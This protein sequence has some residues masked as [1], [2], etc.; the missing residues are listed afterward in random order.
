MTHEI[1]KCKWSVAQLAKK[2][3]ALLV[4]RTLIPKYRCRGRHRENCVVISSISKLNGNG[5]HASL[6][7]LDMR[8]LCYL[9]QK[10]GNIAMRTPVLIRAS[11]VLCK[12]PPRRHHDVDARP[13]ATASSS[14]G[15][16]ISMERAQGWPFGCQCC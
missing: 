3:T 1:T 11:K 12:A 2:C 4:A 13:G 10:W 7:L 9:G 15:Y 14:I 6:A 8:S 16:A 5:V